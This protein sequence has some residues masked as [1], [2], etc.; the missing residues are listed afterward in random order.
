[1]GAMQLES[2]GFPS[3]GILSLGAMGW[4]SDEEMR[5]RPLLSSPSVASTGLGAGN[6]LAS[7][8]STGFSGNGNSLEHAPQ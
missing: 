5:V 4:V 1:M 8:A 6:G 3:G 2:E 7:V